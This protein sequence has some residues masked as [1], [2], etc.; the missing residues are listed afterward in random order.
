MWPI[1]KYK[2]SWNTPIHAPLYLLIVRARKLRKW[3]PIYF[4]GNMHVQEDNSP[5]KCPKAVNQESLDVF[6]Y[7]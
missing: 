7:V 3:S 2:A 4:E 1:I 5:L 6:D